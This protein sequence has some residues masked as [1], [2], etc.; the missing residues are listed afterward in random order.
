MPAPPLEH[1]LLTTHEL[2]REV[3]VRF[4]EREAYVE[5]GGDRLTFAGWDRA[6]DGVAAGFAELGVSPG[7]VVVLTLPSSA[8]YAVCYQAA[9][10]LGAITSG[11]NP[12]L[13]PDE[14]A[15]IMERT[16][17]A[18]V[19]HDDERPVPSFRGRQLARTEL[20]HLRE[21]D[22]TTKEPVPDPDRPVAVVW[23]SGTTGAPKGAVF[24]HRNLAA[25]SV[26]AGAL[27][28]PFDRRISATPFS[29]VGYMTHLFE[30]IE[31]VM[32]TV[33]SV[34]PWKAGG[35]LAQ[36]TRERVTVG[37]GVPSQWRLL[38]DHP[39]FRGAD[40]SSLRICGT[41]AAPVPPELVREMRQ[42]LGCP[43]VVGYTSTEAAITAGSQPDDSPEV[44][45]TTVGRAR[46]NVQIRVVGDDGNVA[47]TDVTGDV[48]CR[49]PAVM[50]GYFR[51]PDQTAAVFRP[52]GWLRTGDL[53][54]LDGNG[55]LMLAGRRSEMYL[56]GGYN[57][58]PV[59][60]ERVLSASPSVAQAAVV[61]KSDPVLGQIGA[62][63]VVPTH[64]STPTL[65]ELR[66]WT[67]QSLADYKAP[68]VLEL[69]DELPLTPVG[70][71]DKL[72]L[73]M[74]AEKLERVRR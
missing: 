4:G 39:D 57:I 10:R 63:F 20:R 42:R 65:E 46:D 15:S 3:A 53:G 1:G 23:T 16:G 41:G 32:T 29:H 26:G 74:W 38:L 73:S 54:R 60:V 19:V 40:L 37:Q 70:K 27:R 7:D 56:R 43:V 25:V 33:V 17:P 8:D 72:A 22:R 21:L 28:A 55:N 34:T 50:R 64:G 61:P 2:L 67:G 48:E 5:A 62:A 59:E 12:R 49:S 36:M 14:V 58:Y 66:R 47:G 52:G 51:D 13:G 69:V 6:A 18:L 30:E 35:V 45:A 24:D 31:F 9:M 71:I 44:I 11:I 68:D